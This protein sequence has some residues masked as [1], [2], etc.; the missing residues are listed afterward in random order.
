MIVTVY[1]LNSD[2]LMY[3]SEVNMWMGELIFKLVFKERL[4]TKRMP[5]IK[6]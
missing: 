2:A 6:L 1:K 4:K 3:S 5:E